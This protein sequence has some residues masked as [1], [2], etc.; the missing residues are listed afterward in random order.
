MGL[1][2][3]TSEMQSE[4]ARHM[5]WELFYCVVGTHHPPLLGLLDC[6]HLMGQ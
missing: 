5:E 6:S 1:V 4:A 3:M 2:F